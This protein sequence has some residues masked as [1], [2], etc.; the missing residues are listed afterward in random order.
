MTG[1]CKHDGCKFRPSFN[2]KGKL[3]SFC[4]KH[5][6]AE[7]VNVK[8]K[9]CEHEGCDNR[10]SF[11]IKGKLPRFCAKHKTSEMVNV[12]HKSC[13]HEGCNSRTLYGKPGN[14]KSHCH[15]H[16]QIGMIR[17]PNSKCSSRGCKEL[18]IWG[19]N[20]VPK[21]CELH[22]TAEEHN[23]VEKKCSS[24]N[25]MSV[26][27]KDNKCEF[28]NPKSF[29]TAR[30]AKQ[31]A[32]MAH[33][34]SRD[35]SGD[36]TDKIVE[37]GACGMERP[38]RIYDLS[39]KIIA[40]ECDEHQ[41]RSI[42]YLCEQTR[43]AN[44]GQSFGGVPVYFIRWN[45]D[46]YKPENDKKNPEEVSRRHKLVGDLIRDIK[47]NKHTLPKGLVS[48]LYMYYHGWDSLAK[49]EWNVLVKMEA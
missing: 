2:I 15:K 26:L 28:C 35:L 21:H 48:V 46:D 37:G 22:K 8:D 13:E 39:D 38:D 11:N 7:M 18:A 44:I 33:L 25:L 5:K 19:S 24:C 3:P 4:A 29:E 12:A 6:T 42:H 41:H 30:L 43:M 16:R 34:D 40:L 32:L 49:A 1:K 20:L 23:L 27:D 9:S 14:P 47:L 36:S 10:P 45:P 31:N 17:K